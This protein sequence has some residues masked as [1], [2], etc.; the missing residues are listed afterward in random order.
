MPLQQV[1]DFQA[2]DLGTLVHKGKGQ[3]DRARLVGTVDFLCDLCQ[4][5]HFLHT[6]TQN[7]AHFPNTQ[8][9]LLKLGCG[10]LIGHSFSSFPDKN[11]KSSQDKS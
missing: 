3:I 11:K 9:N 7:L 2:K 5:G 6:V 8:C 1:G 4:V 10:R